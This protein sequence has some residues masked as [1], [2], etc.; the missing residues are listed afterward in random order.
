MAAVI[1]ASTA[2]EHAFGRRPDG[3]WFA[4][5][6]VNLIGEH[7]DYNGGFVLPMALDFGVAVTV[8]ARSDGML[9]ARSLQHP[10]DDV[11]VPL[12]DLAPARGPEGWAAYPAG[13]V[14]AL[15]DAG[16][17]IP[18]ID[19]VVDGDVPQ[20]A[21]LSSSAAL[22]CATA[23][24]C[25]ERFGLALDRQELAAVAQRAE[26][27]FVGMPCGIMD[28]SASLLCRAQNALFLDTMTLDAVHVPLDLA[29]A[30]QALL[31]IDTRAPHRLVDGEY[32]DRRRACE[33]AARRLGVARLRD[34]ET[35]RMPEAL[36]R[37][38]SPTLRRRVRHVVTENA[39]V[40]EVV[41][42]LERRA[43]VDIGPLLT[44]SHESLRDDYEVSA[45]ELDLAVDAAHGRRRHR[46]PDDRGRL[47]RVRPR[48]GR[49]AG[50]RIDR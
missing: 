7:T 49:R 34:I 33:E 32:A 47:R 11:D 1:D 10:G 29:A 6:R 15:L 4:P 16:H 3:C 19:V 5:G 44:A 9:R 12:N 18:G 31:V 22:E 28:Q 27:E 2:F 46:C 14:W 35:D 37:L 24:A 36:A 26:N 39:R 41:G 17:R 45:P 50:G 8:G 48:P 42:L 38:D 43:V 13:V 20:G 25:A 23:L 40:L 21:G 30:G